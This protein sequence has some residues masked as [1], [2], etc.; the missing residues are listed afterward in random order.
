MRA[1]RLVAIVL[2]LQTRGR[3]TA[4]D[5]AQ[6]LSVSERTIYRDMSALSLA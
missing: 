3:M 5:L 6:R 2:L 1:E 4:L